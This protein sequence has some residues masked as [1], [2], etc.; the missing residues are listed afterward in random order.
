MSVKCLY[1]WMLRANIIMCQN[2]RLL[3]GL[4]PEIRNKEMSDRLQSLILSLPTYSM[5]NTIMQGKTLSAREII[6]S[7]ICQV[8]F[9]S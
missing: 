2:S 8:L 5:S 6:S 3:G 7:C 9:L 1:H 4:I